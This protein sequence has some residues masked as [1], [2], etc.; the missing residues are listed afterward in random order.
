MKNLMSNTDLYLN[1]HIFTH[2]RSHESPIPEH[3]YT[4]KKKHKKERLQNLIC[5]RGRKQMKFKVIY[6]KQK[7]KI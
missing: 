6:K 2:T 5:F 3:M 1:E 7:F 4:C